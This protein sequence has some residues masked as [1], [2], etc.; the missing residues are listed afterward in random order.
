MIKEYKNIKSQSIKV[1]K[2]KQHKIQKSSLKLLVVFYNLD[3]GWTTDVKQLSG[4]E[5]HDEFSFSM[6]SWF[7]SE[8]VRERTTCFDWSEKDK[9]LASRSS[10]EL[11]SYPG[12]TIDLGL[13]KPDP[14]M[15]REQSVNSSSRG[16][17]KLN[18][19]STSCPLTSFSG[20]YRNNIDPVFWKNLI[21]VDSDLN[22]H[23]GLINLE[24]IFVREGLSSF[25]NATNRI[26]FNH[27]L[28]LKLIPVI[29]VWNGK[30][31]IL[32]AEKF[33]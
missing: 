10:T 11:E 14:S 12:M 1:V 13:S 23:G 26:H 17:L 20:T 9:I 22:I 15:L 21:F 25:L 18:T 33:K 5:I 7:E 28:F 24:I 6:N 8:V 31:N 27:A 2:H 4:I 19:N 32:E 29:L 3:S 16:F 30:C